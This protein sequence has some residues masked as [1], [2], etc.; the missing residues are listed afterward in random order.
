MSF[1]NDF[2]VW[3]PTKLTPN[4]PKMQRTLA[5]EVRE[6]GGTVGEIIGTGLVSWQ[7]TAGIGLVPFL[8]KKAGS[9]ECWLFVRKGERWSLTRSIADAMQI[10][11]GGAPKRPYRAD[12][13][14][15]NS[16][17]SIMTRVLGGKAAW[18]A[19]MA[20]RWREAVV[21]S[22]IEKDRGRRGRPP[23]AGTTAAPGSASGSGMPMAVK[24]E[25]AGHLR[26]ARMP[27]GSAPPPSLPAHASPL[28]P[29]VEAPLSSSGA[30]AAAARPA[31]AFPLSLEVASQWYDA[32]AAAFDAAAAAA[33]LRSGQALRAMDTHGWEDFEINHTKVRDLEKNI[34][35]K[36]K[37]LDLPV[38]LFFSVC[39]F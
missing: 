36:E 32:A 23:A 24:P 22:R 12:E 19:E 1:L 6:R 21:S 34:K 35:K 38:A 28:A 7:G 16:S 37:K 2:G 15:L 3:I 14:E 10:I 9:G 20:R 11:T 30:V 33:P 25:P 31:Y 5:K 18:A 13:R 39:S 8:A 4:V 26:G 17:K 27:G 29:A